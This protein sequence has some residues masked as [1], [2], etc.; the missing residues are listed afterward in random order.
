MK[1]VKAKVEKLLITQP[2]G[3]P[4]VHVEKLQILL[5]GIKY[6][7]HF[8][9]TRNADVRTARLLSKGIETANLRA[10]TIISQEELLEISAEMGVETLPDDLEANITLSG[11]PDLTK[12]PAGSFLRF[13]R[14]AILYVTSE[15]LP[16][17]VVS[18]NMMKRAVKK[19]TALR[20][21]KAAY[22][23]RGLTAL[24]FAAGLIK[25][26]DE[27]E[28]LYPQDFEE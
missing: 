17:V 10:V 8:G 2:F 14:N 3:Q 25:E 18:Q 28:V 21:A 19:E 7:R 22:G 24:V 4:P 27:V 11:L 15:N 5:D 26:G 23:K 12:V 9:K 6:D 1:I 16:C 13:P 20:F